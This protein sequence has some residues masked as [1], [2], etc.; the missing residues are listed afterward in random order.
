MEDST[1]EILNIEVIYK[2]SKLVNNQFVVYL[3]SHEKCMLE[4]VCRGSYDTSYLEFWEPLVETS[5][6]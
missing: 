5:Y 3:D 1:E 6:Y 2:E 4:G